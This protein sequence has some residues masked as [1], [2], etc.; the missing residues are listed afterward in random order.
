MNSSFLSTRFGRE[1][2]FIIVHDD[3]YVVYVHDGFSF[4]SVKIAQF[5]L[6]LKIAFFALAI[7]KILIDIEDFKW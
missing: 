1:S 6:F 2:N 7:I 5:L 3:N 4:P